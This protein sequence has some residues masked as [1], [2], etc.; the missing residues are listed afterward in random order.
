MT[1]LTFQEDSY[2]RESDAR[3]EEIVQGGL[4]LDNTIFYPQGGG[5][6]TDRGSVIAEGVEFPIDEVR[7]IEGRIVHRTG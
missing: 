1:R 2:L 4:V 7:R 6:D 3:I 5:Q